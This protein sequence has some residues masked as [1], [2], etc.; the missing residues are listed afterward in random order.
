MTD[1]HLGEFVP[2]ILACV[3]Y[4]IGY[5]QRSLTLRRR[6]R[7]VARWRQ[8]SF[9][10][11]VLLVGVVQLP[12]F[13]SM[14]DDVLAAHMLQHIAI[15]DLASLLIVLGLTGPILGPLLQSRAARLTRA[16]GH[17][18]VAL[19]LWAIDL[20]LWHLP[21]LYQLAIRHDLVHALEHACLLWFGCLLWL[22]LIGPLPKPAWFTG[23]ARLGY[24]IVVRFA[25]AVLANALI[26]AQTVFYPVYRAT[27]GPR[28]LNPLSDQN[29]AGGI[30]MV[31]QVLLTTAV[32]A[33]LFVRFA[34][35]DEERQQLMDVAARRGA[36][37]SDER[38]ARAVAAGAGP[39][40]LE[41]LLIDAERPADQPIG[42]GGRGSA[43]A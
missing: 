22:A 4:V 3:A 12:P 18:V 11:G 5:R 1:P 30:M 14:A 21:L 27:D 15:G 24:V 8:W 41:R 38:A 43:E 34:R 31:E 36:P 32:L 13:D 2:P 19:L 7:P 29:A 23:W 20:Y 9:V 42:D 40:L 33:W 10:V 26:W 17:P 37:L 35:E 16:V 25:G 39:R 6:G 28:G